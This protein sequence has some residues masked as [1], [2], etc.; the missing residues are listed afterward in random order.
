MSALTL[1]DLGRR[2]SETELIDTEP[3]DIEE[4]RRCLQ[5][6]ATV[7]TVTLTRRPILRWLERTMARVGPGERV[8]LIDVGYGYGDVLRAIRAWSRRRGFVL[9]L[10]GLCLLYTSPSPRDRQ[11]SRM[12]SSA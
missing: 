12:P 1:R 2:T 4:Y 9:D 7:N 3:V 11:K 10:V 8:S 6:L 5:D